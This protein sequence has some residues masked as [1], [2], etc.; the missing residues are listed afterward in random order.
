MQKTILLAD[1]GATKTAWALL[2]GKKVVH[3]QTQGISPYLMDAN[4]IIEV[5]SKE[6][7]PSIVKKKITHIHYYGTGCKA[8]AKARIVRQALKKVFPESTIQVTHDLMAAAVSLCGNSKGIACIL[9]TGSGSCLFDGKRIIA[10]SPGLGYV[11]GDEGSGVYFGKQLIRHFL[12]GQLDTH[13]SNSFEKK[14]ELN[15][16]KILQAVYR[17][18]LPNRFLSQLAIFL[19]ENR[20]HYIIENIIEDGLRDFFEP[21]LKRYPSIH[22]LPVH[23]VGG[24]AWAFKDKLKELCDH[25]GF[26]M[27]KVIKQPME[28]LIDFYSNAYHGK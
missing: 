21:H 7:P 8:V 24:V 17:E 19:S 9:G 15:R 20:G 4:R 26:Q 12:Y 13:L 3:V 6:L 25:Y 27:G 18:P 16:D 23:F 2:M 11:L 5:L 10:H 28:G 22:A 14:F 1:S